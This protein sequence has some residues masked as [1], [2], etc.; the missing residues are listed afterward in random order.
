MLVGWASSPVLITLASSATPDMGLVGLASVMIVRLLHQ[1]SVRAAVWGGMLLFLLGITIHAD[2]VL[3]GGSLIALAETVNPSGWSTSLVAVTLG[4][5]TI[6]T[7][8]SIGITIEAWHQGK[9]RDDESQRLQR[10][11][12]VLVIAV[13]ILCIA[14][15]SIRLMGVFQ[16]LERVDITLAFA[17]IALS[18]AVAQVWLRMPTAHFFPILLTVI[19][20][21][22]TWVHALGQERDLRQGSAVV[23]RAMASSVNDRGPVLIDAP[24]DNVFRYTL[25]R[26]C[27]RTPESLAAHPWLV[28]AADRDAKAM[29]NSEVVGRFQ[30]PDGRTIEL[31]KA[32]SPQESHKT[33][34][35]ESLR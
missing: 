32:H 10:V 4:T 29:F 34:K 15:G 19:A 1:P 26:E 13:P 17:W 18:I 27:V 12:A 23:A 2:L 14:I 35:L 25:Y 33:S 20:A 6:V 31:L 11:G 7:S 28:T 8:W 16:Y 5:F 21:K 9:L 3:G 22:V 24:V 30:F